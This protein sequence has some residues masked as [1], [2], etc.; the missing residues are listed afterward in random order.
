[1]KRSAVMKLG[2][3]V[4]AVVLLCGCAMFGKG[5]SDE[6]L[7]AATIA[8]WSAALAAQDAD[9]V[10]A[11]YSEDFETPDMPD[12]E[13]MRELIEMAIDQG[14]LEE[15]EINTDEAETVIEG[16]KASVGPVELSGAMGSMM[17]DL[18]LQKEN[19]A[20]LIVGSEGG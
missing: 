12:K 8:Q 7:I 2:A 10:M 1:M 13:S 3:C 6:E 16:N 17:I 18:T 15:V 4:L 11:T 19:G 9:N 14:Y 5:P 20:W